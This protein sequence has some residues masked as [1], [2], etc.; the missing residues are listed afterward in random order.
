MSN[1]VIR[2]INLKKDNIILSVAAAHSV[3]EAQLQQDQAARLAVLTGASKIA[4]SDVVIGA[5]IALPISPTDN[6]GRV[7]ASA[8][9]INGVDGEVSDSCFRAFLGQH[10]FFRKLSPQKKVPKTLKSL[11]IPTKRKS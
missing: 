10:N 2:Q 3:T 8:D 1:A 11:K 4:Q 7:T 6:T 5:V 9:T